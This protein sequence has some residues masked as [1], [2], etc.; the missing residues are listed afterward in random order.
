MGHREYIISAFLSSLCL[1]ISINIGSPLTLL[2]S[3]IMFCI[4]L[5]SL[6][7]PLATTNKISI[8]KYQL[9]PKQIYKGQKINLKINISNQSIFPILFANIEVV[10]NLIQQQN[11]VN[12][13]YIKPKKSKEVSIDLIG[14]KRGFSEN[15]EIAV[16]CYLFFKLISPKIIKIKANLY[17]YPNFSQINYHKLINTAPEQNISLMYKISQEGDFFAVRE[18]VS[19]DDIKK[20]LWKQWAKVGKPVVKEKAEFIS[21]KF[22]FLINNISV[23]EQEDEEFV[24]KINSF[25]KY[26]LSQNIEI[27]LLTITNTDQAVKIN[28]LKSSLVFLAKLDF[29]KHLPQNLKNKL[30]ELSQN[31]IIISS[32]YLTLE[33]KNQQITI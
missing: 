18:Y 10:N 2:L 13:F 22:F 27:N 29:I 3:I 28:D 8:D 19:T 20:I 17:I 16:Q 31:I 30:N 12:L 5:I 7:Y 33:T 15:I 11:K 25:L 32:K 9:T 1:L 26:L 24:E 14:I 21:P 4:L 23:D 6:I